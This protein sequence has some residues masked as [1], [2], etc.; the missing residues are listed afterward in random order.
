MP[1]NVTGRTK[2]FLF[3]SRVV[4]GN[5]TL[6]KGNSSFLDHLQLKSYACLNSYETKMGALNI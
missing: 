2:I 6:K 3:R 4:Y 1:Q 5:L